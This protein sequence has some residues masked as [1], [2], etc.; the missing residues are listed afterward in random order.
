MSASASDI[1]RRRRAG[2]PPDRAAAPPLVWERAVAGD[3]RLAALRRILLEME[4]VLVAFS[5]GADSALLAA[6]AHWTLGARALMV[7]ARSAFHPRRDLD[8]ARRLT[9]EHGWRHRELATRELD[10]PLLAAN[11]ADRCYRCKLALFRRLREIA[12][13]GNLRWLADGSNLDDRREHR[14]GARA[15]AELGVRSPLQEAGCGKAEIR[16]A[17]R[18]LGLATADKPSSSCLAT[19]FPY[20]TPLTAGGL[21]AVDRAEEAI[22]ALGFTQVRLRAHGD[23]ARIEL[24]PEEL[25]RAVTAPCRTLIA[26]AAR[27]GGFRH[28]A[29]DLGG[30]RT[31]SLD[32][33]LA[34]VSH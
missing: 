9:R 16:A 5:G 11:P 33:A 26:R 12:A 31:G 32:A 17:S 34:Q 22:R 7:T 30:Y 6:A 21:A 15:A 24:A 19:R 28:A 13:A 20:G 29:L 25:P 18:L 8:D 10:D 2:Q 14:P 27:A 23:V 1:P 4:S 3:A